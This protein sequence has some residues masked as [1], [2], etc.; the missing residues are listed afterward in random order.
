MADER[1][2]RVRADV[3]RAAGDENL[4]DCNT[5]SSADQV[6]GERL[7][8]MV[9]FHEPAPAY[10][11]AMNARSIGLVIMALGALGVA[12]GLLI[13]FGLFNWFGRLPGDIRIEGERTRFYFPITSM[14]LVSVILSLVLSLWRRL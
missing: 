13:Y 10:H 14:I 9:R 7:K 5:S 1:R 8:V 11:R 2:D 3:A 12:V 4:H 6:Q